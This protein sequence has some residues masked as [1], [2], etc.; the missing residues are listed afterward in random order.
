M[1]YGPSCVPGS[2]CASVDSLEMSAAE[3]SRILSPPERLTHRFP[4]LEPG[5]AAHA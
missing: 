3:R 4:G 2:Q 1:R 5:M